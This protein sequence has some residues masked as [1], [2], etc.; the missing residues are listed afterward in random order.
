[1]SPRVSVCIPTYNG[2]RYLASTLQSALS[3]TYTDYEIVIVDDCSSDGSLR[4]IEAI[5]HPRVRIERNEENRGPAATWNR[6]VSLARGELV[7]LLCQDDLIYPRALQEAVD[8]FEADP[9]IVLASSRRD[10]I[11]EQGSV[12]FPGRGSRRLRGAVDGRAAIRAVARSGTNPIGEP[13]VTLFR[14]NVF[15]DVG[16][17]SAQERYM[18][19]VELWIRLLDRGNLHYDQRVLSAFRVS[20][21]SWSAQL[22]GCQAL[23]ARRLLRGL[24]DSHAGSVKRIDRLVGTARATGLACGRRVLYAWA[25]RS[26]RLTDDR[27]PAEP[28]GAARRARLQPPER[29]ERGSAVDPAA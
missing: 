2:E 9:T 7:K 27:R 24:G 26:E 12:I 14:R 18:I 1:V 28:L 29:L 20:R 22:A 3:Q 4:L 23:E 10:V 19:D 25:G 13:S 16:G 17:F 5:D 21:S 6:A 11:D 15:D 8:A